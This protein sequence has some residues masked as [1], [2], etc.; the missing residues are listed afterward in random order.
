MPPSFKYVRG[1]S[2]HDNHGLG[3]FEHDSRTARLAQTLY[4]QPPA[5]DVGLRI[6]VACLIV[7]EE[8]GSGFPLMLL[9]GGGLNSTIAGL[10]SGNPFPAIEECRRVPLHHGGPAQR[11]QR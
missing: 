6:I 1:D 11:S 3:T 9:P 8:A 2:P 7:S 10:K 5:Q 4:C